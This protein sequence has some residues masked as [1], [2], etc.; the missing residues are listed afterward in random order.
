MVTKYDSATQSC[1]EVQAPQTGPS[2]RDARNVV[3]LM[4]LRDPLG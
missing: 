2:P 1:D 3:F 4:F